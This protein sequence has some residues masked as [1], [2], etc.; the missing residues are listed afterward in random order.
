MLIASGWWRDIFVAS[1]LL[2][3]VI[4]YSRL[5]H[6]YLSFFWSS[7]N[8]FDALSLVN[9][10]KVVQTLHST[11]TLYYRFSDELAI[12]TKFLLCYYHLLFTIKSLQLYIHTHTQTHS[13]CYCC[14]CCCNVCAIFFY[15]FHSSGLLMR[16]Y[17]TILRQLKTQRLS[18]CLFVFSYVHSLYSMLVIIWAVFC[19]SSLTV[20]RVVCYGYA[21]YDT[22]QCIAFILI[23]LIK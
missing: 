8:A 18:L 11:H 2:R 22:M 13:F 20:L 12:C 23:C 17:L 21:V 6:P 3:T 4:L 14:C 16:S 1:L 5:T 7:R 9:L 15:N 19:L 10:T